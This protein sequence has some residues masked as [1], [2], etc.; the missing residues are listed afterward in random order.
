MLGI[1]LFYFH[2]VTQ[3][4]SQSDPFL[5][6]LEAYEQGDYPQA[7]LHWKNSLKKSSRATGTTLSWLG[8]L[9]AKEGR[10][11]EAETLMK[12]AIE[13]NKLTFGTQSLQTSIPMRHLAGVYEERGK[14]DD[15]KTLLLS[16]IQMSL[17]AQ[18]GTA[19]EEMT[20]ASYALAHI[21]LR[22][23]NSDLAKATLAQSLKVC[24]TTLGKSHPDTLQVRSRLAA[25]QTQNR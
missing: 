15:A 5:Q 20:L 25:I 24:E 16:V 22:Q 19:V 6:G 17:K 21:H 4:S 10:F 14:L 11:D 18:S 8:D 13:S 12:Q 9:M 2:D 7:E 23:R 1:T 3:P